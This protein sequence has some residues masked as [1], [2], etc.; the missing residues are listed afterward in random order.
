V[1]VLRVSAAAE[2][3]LDDICHYIV[4]NSGS[5]DR[6]NKFVDAIAQ[7]LSVLAHSPKAG[8]ART[9]VDVRLRGL[10]IGDYIVYYRENKRRVIISR[11]IQAAIKTQPF[12][13]FIPIGNSA[14]PW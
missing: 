3:D 7:R 8:T 11:I 2:R 4:I 5:I 1:K 10:P 13:T 9:E 6:T 14:L 12:S